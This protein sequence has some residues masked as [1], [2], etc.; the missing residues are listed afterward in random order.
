MFETIC[1]NC[2]RISFGWAH[3]CPYCKKDTRVDLGEAYHKIRDYASSVRDA[4]GEEEED[5]VISE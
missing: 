4:N 5:E 2:G 3:R 1:K